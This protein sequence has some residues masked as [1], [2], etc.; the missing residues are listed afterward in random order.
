MKISSEEGFGM[1]TRKLLSLFQ[2]TR[3]RGGQ[4]AKFD[5]QSEETEILWKST[6]TAQRYIIQLANGI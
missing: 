1:R 5:F 4:V 6:Q 2:V 3:V